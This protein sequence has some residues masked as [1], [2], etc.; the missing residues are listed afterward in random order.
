MAKRVYVRPKDD[1]PKPLRSNWPNPNEPP[2]I[3]YVDGL[4]VE[5]MDF[6]AKTWEYIIYQGKKAIMRYKD[7]DKAKRIFALLSKN[8]CDIWLYEHEPTPAVAD[9]IRQL[10]KAEW[11]WQG[12]F[13]A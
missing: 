11:R 9:N 3:E 5:R 8:R 7:K 1:K 6:Q 10:E 13:G 4:I 12:G 2:E